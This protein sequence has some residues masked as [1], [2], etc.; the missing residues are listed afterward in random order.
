MILS[1][2][3]MPIALELGLVVSLCHPDGT[4]A[5]RG[6]GSRTQDDKVADL[7][8]IGVDADFADY[9]ALTPDGEAFLALA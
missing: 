2:D 6:R 1:H 8:V 9:V 5:A 4:E 3:A 7:R